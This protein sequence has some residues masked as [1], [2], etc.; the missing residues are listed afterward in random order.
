M[1]IP[2]LNFPHAPTQASTFVGQANEGCRATTEISNLQWRPVFLLLW[3]STPLICAAVQWD[4]TLS[5]GAAS[6]A[7]PDCRVRVGAKFLLA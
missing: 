6:E 1:L 5:S 4:T 7:Y 2:S 3:V